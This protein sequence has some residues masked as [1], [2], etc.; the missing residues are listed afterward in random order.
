MKL[1]L[2][3]GTRDFSPKEEMLRQNVINKLRKVFQLYGFSPIE[4]PLLERYEVLSAKFTAGEESLV[5][6]S[7]VISILKGE[8]NEQ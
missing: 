7:E 2:A 5:S 6:I 8:K 1:E 3:K 4:T